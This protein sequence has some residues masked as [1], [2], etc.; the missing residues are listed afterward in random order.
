MTSTSTSMHTDEETTISLGM[1]SGTVKGG[2]ISIEGDGD[3][4]AVFGPQD[5]TQ[6]V[7]FWR[8]LSRV[9]ADMAAYCLTREKEGK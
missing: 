8:Y 7:D 9:A 4:V 2:W 5:S 1:P 6:G 3:T